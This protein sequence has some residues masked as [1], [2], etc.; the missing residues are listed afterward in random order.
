MIH[1]FIDILRK[2]Q[3]FMPLHIRGSSMNI[4]GYPKCI[5]RHP[6]GK[7]KVIRQGRRTLFPVQAVMKD[8][9]AV[10]LFIG[11]ITKSGPVD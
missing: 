1:S 3:I 11:Y 8:H 2:P 6:T 7:I 5:V 4:C 9:G 10:L